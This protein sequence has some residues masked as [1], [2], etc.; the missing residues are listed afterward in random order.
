[1]NSFELSGIWWVPEK[2]GVQIAGTLRYNP[3][4]GAYLDLIGSFKNLPNLA[5]LSSPDIV[6]GFAGGKA[7][8]LYKCVESRTNMNMSVGVPVM[9][10]T[11]YFANIVFLGHHFQREGDVVFTSVSVNYSYLEEWTRITGIKFNLTADE[12]RQLAKYDVSYSFPDKIVNKLKDFDVTITYSFRDGG[13]RLKSIEFIQTTYLEITPSTPTNFNEYHSKFLY[14]LQN[15]LSLGIG[16]AV[17]PLE[18]KGSNNNCKTV[19]KNG[20]TFLSDISIFYRLGKIPDFTKK[21]HPLDAL[22]YYSDIVFGFENCLKNWFSKSELLAPVYDLYFATLYNPAM[23]LQHEFL[24]LVQSIESYH[25]R[26]F[27]GEYVS[28]DEYRPILETLKRSIPA[29]VDNA[30]RESLK[31][32][33]QYLYEYSLKKRLEKII[34]YCGN[35]LNTIIPDKSEFIEDVYNT[36]NFLTHYDKELED[37]TKKGDE[38]YKRTKQLKF[39]IETC[40]LKELGFSDENIFKIVSRNQRYHHILN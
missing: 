11:S 24:S 32:R 28:K 1:M 2:S 26:V 30:F 8:T 40:L 16:C 4:E 25:R 18:I 34:E 13:D 12:N 21:L 31:Y 5:N 10:S 23:Y 15:L 9:M 39:L 29:D 3:V 33:M 37:K 38:L 35:T 20:K 36:R 27:G 6:L 19:L 7:I 17:Y 22:F 14:H